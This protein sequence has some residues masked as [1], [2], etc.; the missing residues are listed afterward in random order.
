MVRSRRGR[1]LRV[2]E[3]GRSRGLSLREGGNGVE[4]VSRDVSIE[5]DLLFHD[6][7]G[8]V[9]RTAHLRGT[10]EERKMERTN[11]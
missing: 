11:E 6:G 7:G 4:G 3:S 5:R 10:I 2:G 9:G 8:V 1:L